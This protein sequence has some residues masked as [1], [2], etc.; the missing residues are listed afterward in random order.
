MA[1]CETINQSMSHSHPSDERIWLV[2]TQDN[3]VGD[4]WQLR[5]GPKNW[6]N[7]RAVSAFIKNEKGQ[8]WI[9]RRG[10]HKRIF[11]DCLDMS[12][13]GHVDWLETYEQAFARELQEEVN[14]NTDTVNKKFLGH[15]TPE[16]N[17]KLSA[18]MYVWEIGMNE[19]PPYNPNDFTEAYWLT[20]D[21]L[22]SRLKNGDRAKSDLPVLVDIFYPES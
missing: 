13:G 5:E 1:I 21:E 2:D 22:R 4:G 17:N 12:M 16:Q 6:Q 11:P 9:P 10:P 3:P 14:L 20:P 7:F 15:L 8:I 18:C 19:T